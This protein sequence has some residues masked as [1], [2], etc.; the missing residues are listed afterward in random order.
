MEALSRQ[1]YPAMLVSQLS[2]RILSAVSIRRAI[3]DHLKGALVS[4][5]SRP[6][7]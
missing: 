2:H 6:E 1:E 4:A 5:G 7:T 3:A